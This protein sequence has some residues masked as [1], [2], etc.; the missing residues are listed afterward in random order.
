MTDMDPSD[1]ILI[2]R[3]AR[4][5][6]A[7]YRT[8]PLEGQGV[9]GQAL[10]LAHA[11]ELDADADAWTE[12]STDEQMSPALTPRDIRIACQLLIDVR[13]APKSLSPDEVAL[14]REHFPEVEEE[15]LDSLERLVGFYTGLLR[16]GPAEQQD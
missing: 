8:V 4:F 11:A 16:G 5:C 13:R 2:A 12:G 1:E 3:L 9:T 15:R 14:V 10:E 6:A 7:L